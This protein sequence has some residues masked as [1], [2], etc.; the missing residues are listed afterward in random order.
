MR[1]TQFL[2]VV[3]L[4]LIGLSFV[5][6]DD[7]PKKSDPAKVVEVLFYNYEDG[8]TVRITYDPIKN[9]VV[10]SEA[11]D[12]HPCPLSLAESLEAKKIADTDVDAA[13]FLK[14]HPKA[15]AHYHAQVAADKKN[16]L[17]GRRIVVVSYWSSP[18]SD[19]DEKA[20]ECLQIHVDLSGKKLVG[21][22]PT[23]KDK[24]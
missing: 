16:S 9:A 7:K 12:A 21:D 22:E 14:K 3:A 24:K 10:K 5:A 19:P 1:G 4:C 2:M 15:T 6:G 17:Y 11:L 18:P 20:H 8:K 23:P 13:K